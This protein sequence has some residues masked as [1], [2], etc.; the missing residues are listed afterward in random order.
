MRLAGRLTRDGAV[1]PLPQRF[2]QIYGVS[3]GMGASEERGRRVAA[4]ASQGTGTRTARGAALMR[5]RRPAAVVAGH[6]DRG[7]AA[8]ARWAV[9]L[10]G[11]LVT[12]SP[13]VVPDAVAA[14]A[15]A[16]ATARATAPADPP[17]PA[18]VAGVRPVA[19]QVDP[20]AAAPGTVVR[21]SG[22]T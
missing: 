3:G 20:E 19:T 13:G 17:A 5:G 2:T 9:V 8:R 21:R 18:A 6:P 7:P 10:A 14:P 4:Q 11:L 12:G 15:T 16:P 1:E 22:T